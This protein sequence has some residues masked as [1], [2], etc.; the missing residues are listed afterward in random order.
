MTN[1]EVLFRMSNNML[2]QFLCSEDFITIKRSWTQSIDGVAQWLSWEATQEFI[3]EWLDGSVAYNE[4]NDCPVK[5]GDYIYFP[6]YTLGNLDGEVAK[7]KVERIDRTIYLEPDE[8]GGR[9]SVIPAFYNKEWFTDV[10]KAKE[11]CK[12]RLANNKQE[13]NK[14]QF[15][16]EGG[17]TCVKCGNHIFVKRQRGPHVGL[18]CSKCGYFVKWLNKEERKF[19]EDDGNITQDKDVPVVGVHDLP[20]E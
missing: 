12:R 14:T 11:E 10:N 8:V 6:K 9:Q 1:R 18:Y 4:Y 19:Y 2:A 5:V 13:L 17:K 16:Y 15:V 3:N 7:R 20:W